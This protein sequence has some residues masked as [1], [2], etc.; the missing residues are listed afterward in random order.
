MKSNIFSLVLVLGL[1]FNSS[2]G[3]DAGVSVAAPLNL[4]HK[5]AAGDKKSLALVASAFVLGSV[6]GVVA[7]FIKSKIS[8]DF[9]R[10]FLEKHW[11]NLTSLKDSILSAEKAK[12]D[13]SKVPGGVSAD[14]NMLPDLYNSDVSSTGIKFNLPK[15]IL[16]VGS[17]YESAT[18]AEAFAG[19]MNAYF[20]KVKA[21]KLLDDK[22]GKPELINAFNTAAWLT[23]LNKSNR[24]V[25]YISMADMI[26][27]KVDDGDG[28]KAQRI[29]ILDELMSWMGRMPKDGRVVVV[30]SVS[31]V[32]NIEK[33]F[34]SSKYFSLIRR[35]EN[36]S[37]AKPGLIL[38]DLLKNRNI[39]LEGVS[40][41]DVADR[42]VGLSWKDIES[43][44][45]M[46]IVNALAGG[47]YALRSVDFEEA[48]SGYS[49][50]KTLMA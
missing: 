42:L 13:F 20:V 2:F 33:S 14:I 30:A 19:E 36:S 28:V 9:I 3:A 46:A 44:V 50:L 18:V 26:L 49:G 6:V 4:A 21:G 39:S 41:S 43:V 15:G 7:P 8:E 47:R 48:M 25:I 16:L 1:G 5:A 11:G 27:S 12:L 34:L 29:K 31:S 32:S 17:E 40:V 38:V 10:P 37:R 45:D 35:V 22:K 23:S 24:V